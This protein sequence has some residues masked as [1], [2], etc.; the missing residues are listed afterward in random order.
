MFNNNAIIPADSNIQI[1]NSLKALGF[2][3]F[4]NDGLPVLLKGEAQHT[5]LIFHKLDDDNIVVEPTVYDKICN[6]SIFKNIKLIKGLTPLSSNYPGNI[7]YNVLR[8]GNYA[9]H[10]LKYTDKTIIE[11]YKNNKIELVNVNQGYSNCTV[12]VV[13]NNSAITSDSGMEKAL[14]N[15]GIDVLLIENGYID[16]PGFDYGFIGGATKL[17]HSKLYLTGDISSH[18][19]YAKIKEFICKN[20]VEEVVLSNNKVIDIGSILFF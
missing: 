13:G 15:C 18:P 14:K 2:N 19:N 20:N 1:I 16:L 6:N 5:D 17:L 10:N 3:V 11:Y 7:A 9:F 12:C 4:L 8:I